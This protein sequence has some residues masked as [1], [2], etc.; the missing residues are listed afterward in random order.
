MNWRQNP[1]RVAWLILTV[2]LAMCCLLAVAV[3]L[4]VR[5]FLLNATRPI[6]AFVT[7][8]AGTVQF[9]PPGA[10]DPTA[11]TD[12]RAMPERSRLITDANARSLLT[13]FSS[14]PSSPVIATIQL[15]QNTDLR[16]VSAHAPR[17]AWN[18]EPVQLTL[19]LQKGRVAVSAQG[20]DGQP[21]RV[22]LSTPHGRA[23]FSNG[24]Y[25]IAIEGDTTQVRTRTGSAAVLA[26]G[27]EVTANTGER[28]SITAGRSPDLPIPSALNLVLN[29]KLE[30][31]FSPPWQEVIKGS[32]GQTPGKI[33]QEMVDQ[34][35]AVRFSHKTEDGAH[36]EV[37][38]KQDIN[39]DVQGYDS[40]VLRLDLKLLYQ[41][42]PGGG[43]LAS[44]YPMM[45][46]I[47]YTDIYGKDLH[48]YQGFYYMDLPREST[49]AKP[50]G[51]K[52]LQEIWYTYESPNLF[53]LLIET[54]PARI[55]SITVYASG[56]DYDSLVS[57]VAL[58][59]R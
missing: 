21:I 28:I 10:V 32:S 29:G 53:D 43:Y 39:R 50:T 27:R 6:Q 58:S 17:F 33:T 12:R 35:Q 15:Y 47:G 55:N 26:A 19:D 48:W 1:Q 23:T 34:R 51:E 8:T 14:D 41:S 11:V 16:L 59:V 5:S 30:G 56:H 42:V 20:A 46:D 3:P 9:F 52:V 31:R 44:E 54:R 7:A 25:D 4:G 24:S 38:L 22:Q 49:W 40:L 45:V 13:V 18:R 37:G 36:N 57:D 2:N